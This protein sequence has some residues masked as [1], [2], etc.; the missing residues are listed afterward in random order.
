[1]L[2]RTKESLPELAKDV[3]L[4]LAKVL[5]LEQGEGLSREQIL[6][7]AL[8][9]AHH[10]NNEFLIAE[11]SE[12]TLDAMQKAAKLAVSLMAM[13]NIYYR[14][15]HLSENKDLA[16]LPANLRMQGML[17]PGVDKLS[18]EVLCLAVSVLNGCGA[19]ISAHTRLLTEQGFSAQKIARI[20]RIAAVI[21]AVHISQTL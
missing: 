13:T 19:C 16:Q 15:V 3:R 11:L 6:G 5:D 8:A 1:M 2:E 7:S 9:V 21:N 10:L 18:F 14:F 12:L 4:N 17:N 20:G